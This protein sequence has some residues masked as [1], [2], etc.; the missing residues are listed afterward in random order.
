MSDPTRP[1]V[2][3]PH[4]FFVKFNAFGWICVAGGLAYIYIQRASPSLLT[5]GAGFGLVLLGGICVDRTPV[6]AFV[7]DI[8]DAIRAWRGHDGDH[9]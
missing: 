2:D 9:S 3:Q 8:T 1:T 4:S 7:S 5:L 6:T